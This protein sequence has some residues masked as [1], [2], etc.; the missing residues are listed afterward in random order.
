MTDALVRCAVA[1]AALL[2]GGCAPRESVERA[3][4]RPARAKERCEMRR[5]ERFDPG[6]RVLERRA[7]TPVRQER[8]EVRE[9]IVSLPCSE[10]DGGRE[11]ESADACRRRAERRARAAY[12]DARLTSD[13]LPERYQ[14]RMRLRVAD[15]ERIEVVDSLPQAQARLED[16]GQDGVTV[17]VI[18]T[19]V[20][21]APD[22]PRHA[23]VR[24]A[25]SRA[26]EVHAALRVVVVVALPDDPVRAL[27][28]LRQRA[29]RARVSVHGVALQDERSLAIEIG[30]GR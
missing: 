2:L 15:E 1:C 12:P 23:V 26:R 30:C 8:G 11:R 21:P 13:V 24:A 22:A 27:V 5:L 18:A 9:H 7:L 10:A 6:M 16:L 29:T 17:K 19:E 3:P 28:V 4:A 20:V 25:V 14:L